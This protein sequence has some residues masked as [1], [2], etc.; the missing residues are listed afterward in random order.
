MMM[1][2]FLPVFLAP[3]LALLVGLAD[4]V[5][6][7]RRQRDQRGRSEQAVQGT[8]SALQQ[9]GFF[10]AVPNGCEALRPLGMSR[11]VRQMLQVDIIEEQSRLACPGRTR[12]CLIR[13]CRRSPLAHL[14]GIFLQGH[15]QSEHDDT[16]AY[17]DCF[18]RPS[19][20]CLYYCQVFLSASAVLKEPL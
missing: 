1:R 20:A 12:A 2:K 11:I 15:S 9:A 10:Q 17:T 18:H 8:V 16:R 3:T 14:S 19:H 13:S 6:G 5:S 7:Q 4:V